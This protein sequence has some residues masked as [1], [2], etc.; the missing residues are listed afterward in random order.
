MSV[1]PESV[2]AERR[3]IRD[4]YRRR[5]SRE[6]K[7]APWQPGEE[8]MR[9]SRRRRAIALLRDAGVFP[10]AG[11]PCLEVGCGALG[12]L[13]DLLSWGLRTSDLHGI[14]LDPARIARA[15][16]AMPGADLRT[17]DAAALPWPDDT[18][19]LVIASTVFT[20]VLDAGV[21]GAIAG[22]MTR[23][24]APGGAVLVYDFRVPSPGNAD[25]RPLPSRE[26]RRLFPTLDGWIASVTLAPPLARAV[27][28]VSDVLAALLEALPF[29]RTHLLAILVKG[30]APRANASAA[31][32][33]DV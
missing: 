2:F 5:A 8:L 23:V 21:R 9:A 7:Y 26:L 29:L 28:P 13:A 19:R 30:G 22:E 10:A 1:T 20:S 31:G 11:E 33:E 16:E 32:W 15:R 6:V 14:D 4:V 17:G 25:V 3:R 27:A 24:V 18:F 12:W